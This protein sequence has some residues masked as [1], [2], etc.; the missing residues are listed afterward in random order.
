MLPVGIVMGWDHSF[1]PD[2]LLWAALMLAALCDSAVGI[3]TLH[4]E[5][6]GTA[7]QHLQPTPR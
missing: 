3:F 6:G 7:N 4:F 5:A 1:E 2:A